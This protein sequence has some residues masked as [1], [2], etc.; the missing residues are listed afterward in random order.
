M[1]NGFH[2]TVTAYCTLKPTLKIIGFKQPH[3]NNW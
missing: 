2:F 3:E 1:N